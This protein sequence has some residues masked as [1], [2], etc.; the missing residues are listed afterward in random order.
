MDLTATKDQMDMLME[1]ASMKIKN[2]EGYAKALQDIESVLRDLV[3]MYV[4]VLKEE[5]GVG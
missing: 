3:K 5:A 4:R 1:F 2:P